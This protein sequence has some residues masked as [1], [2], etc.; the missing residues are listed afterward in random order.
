MSDKAIDVIAK[1]LCVSG[2]DSTPSVYSDLA[3]DILAALNAAGYAV[4][5]LAA[6]GGQDDDGQEYFG[7]IRVDHTGRGTEYP[8]IYIDGWPSTPEEARREAAELL[9]A[10]AAAE[11]G[12]HA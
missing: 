3:R 4:T 8:R 2:Y 11:E 6:S 10:A 5:K 7:G 1:R 12:A 9:S